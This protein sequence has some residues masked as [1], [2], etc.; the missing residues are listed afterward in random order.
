MTWIVTYDDLEGHRGRKKLT[1]HIQNKT[2]AKYAFK[3]LYPK[4]LI[5]EIINDFNEDSRIKLTAET[6]K[7]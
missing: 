4:Y 7:F 1:G 5:L 2:E 6:G 3:Y